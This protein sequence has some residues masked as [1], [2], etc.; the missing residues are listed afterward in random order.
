MKERITLIMK[1]NKILVIPSITLL[2]FIIFSILS[3]AYALTVYLTDPY[4][5]PSYNGGPFRVTVSDP[6][7][8]NISFSSFDTFCLERNEFFVINTSYYGS[9]DDVA[10]G[11]GG[12]GIEGPVIG[13]YYDPL[14]IRTIRLYNY[15]LDQSTLTNNERAAIQLAIWRIEEEVNGTYGGLL[16]PE[17]RGLADGYYG[18][19]ANNYDIDRTINVLNLYGNS[20]LSYASRKQSQLVQVPEPSTLLLLGAG[21]VGLG[22]V[23][24]K[25]KK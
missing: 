13:Q 24:R 25:R 5:L 20:N 17:I 23:V 22:L 10:I 18:N 2:T 11:G 12:G 3:N 9:I 14:D 1:K 8:Y 16:T 15:Y 4:A 7:P 19:Q 6:S 21:L